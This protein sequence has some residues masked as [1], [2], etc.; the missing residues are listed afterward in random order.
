[1]SDLVDFQGRAIRFTEER[2]QHILEHPE[3]R[4]MTL[5]LEETLRTPEIV[6]RS[7]SDA[8]V[9]LFYRYYTATVVGDKYLCVVVKFLLDDAFVLT[10]Y[11][12]DK[13]K[14]GESLL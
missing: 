2:Q 8:T 11:L 3:M 7:R 10:A 12:T 13:P 1:M 9:V 6:R 4:S 5:A 14:Q